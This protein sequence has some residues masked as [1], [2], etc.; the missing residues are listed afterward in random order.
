LRR[1]AERRAGEVIGVP[2]AALRM[3]AATGIG[4]FTTNGARWLNDADELRFGDIH[5]WLTPG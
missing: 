3:D 2:H 4:W 1:S 5:D